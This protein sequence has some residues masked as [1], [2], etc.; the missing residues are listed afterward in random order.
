MG[1]EEKGDPR[2][3]QA[4]VSLSDPTQ[5]DSEQIRDAYAIE[6]RL[7]LM[8]CLPGERVEHLSE[9]FEGPIILTLRSRE[10][11][12]RFE[13]DADGWMDAMIP[14]L[15]FVTMV[16]VETRFSRYAGKLQD[17][18]ISVIAS[19]HSNEMLTMD[20][21]HAL[22]RELRSFGDIPKIAV[23]PHDAGELLTL[24]EFTHA[25][26]KPVIVSVTGIL[27]RYARPLL[28][29][30]GSLFTYCYIDNPTSPGQYSLEEI[31]TLGRLLSPAIMDTWF[32][33]KP[34][35]STGT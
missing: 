32:N 31:K 28:P 35:G 29:L 30:F 11:G 17:L 12:G 7:D 27:C 26:A 22:Y 5:F 18:G 34:S 25:T 15:P 8:P 10:E 13:G 14:Y 24:L 9:S 1:P 23:Q 20:Q 6:I 16:D 4:V 33:G 21:L 3:I 19:C 2:I